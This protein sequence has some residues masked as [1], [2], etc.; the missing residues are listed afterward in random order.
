MVIII[1]TKDHFAIL[2][3]SSKAMQKAVGDLAYLLAITMV[4]NSIQPVI[5]GAFRLG[6]DRVSLVH[7]ARVE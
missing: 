5:S 3:T 7:D 6:T 4:L 1:L 2:F